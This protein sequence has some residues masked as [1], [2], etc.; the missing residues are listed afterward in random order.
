MFLKERR[1]VCS[2]G[3]EQGIGVTKSS[4]QWQ[5][6]LAPLLMVV[7]GLTN[8]VHERARDKHAPSPL[9]VPLQVESAYLKEGSVDDQAAARLLVAQTL[10]LQS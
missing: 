5:R 3:L 9:C 10:K 6:L 1:E 7:D 2:W 8:A 4:L